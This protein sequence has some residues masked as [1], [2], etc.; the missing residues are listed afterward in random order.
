[1]KFKLAIGAIVLMAIAFIVNTA[2]LRSALTDGYQVSEIKRFLI[3]MESASNAVAKTLDN[4]DR[5]LSV[6]EMREMLDGQRQAI[7]SFWESLLDPRLDDEEIRARGLVNLS[8]VLKSGSKLV[9]TANESRQ[10]DLSPVLV[11]QIMEISKAES[12]SGLEFVEDNDYYY[13]P[14]L[15]FDNQGRWIVSLIFKFHKIFALL[16]LGDGFK[17]VI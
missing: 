2:F 1:M 13:V 14:H 8:I 16:F 15:L 9:T 6:T 7:N 5:R 17:L 3:P 11:E 4:N 12:S 10:T